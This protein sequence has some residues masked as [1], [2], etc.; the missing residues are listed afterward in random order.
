[1]RSRFALAFLLMI[2]AVTAQSQDLETDKGKLSYALGWD[3]GS[4]VKSRGEQ[5]DLESVLAAMRDNVG[6][7]EPRVAREEMITLLQA[8]QEQ[9]QEERLAAFQKMAEENKV[10][11]EQFLAENRNKTN[12]QVLPS[13]VQYRVIEEGAGA[14]PGMESTVRLHY[15]GSK[16]DGLEFDSSFARGVPEEIL[17]NATLAGWQEVLP[18][19]KQG[20]TWQ[21]FVPPELA[22]GER[23]RPPVG[24]NEALKFDLTLVEIVE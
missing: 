16:I 3:F 9:I 11:S 7:S 4:T 21:V 24:P 17:V 2:V 20:S 15:R 8:F 19:M 22:F 10:K 12:I 23:G 18:L 1:M 5:F 6:G 14:R 13:G